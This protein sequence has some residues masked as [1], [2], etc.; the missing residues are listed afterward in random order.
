MWC[1][2]VFQ[3]LGCLVVETVFPVAG[4]DRI[5]DDGVRLNENTLRKLSEGKSFREWQGDGLIAGSS[6]EGLAVGRDWGHGEADRDHMWLC[7][8]D[9]AVYV[10][11]PGHQPPEHANLV[12]TPHKCPAAYTRL[13]VPHKD[14]LLRA[15]VRC[16]LSF[17]LSVSSPEVQQCVVNE[18]DRLWL[19][20]RHTLEVMQSPL[21][22]TISGPA[23]QQDGG[24]Y[25]RVY[26]LVCSGPHPAMASYKQRARKHWPSRVLLD[27]LVKQPMLLVMVGPK[28]AQD[29]CLMF[30][31]SWS[32]LELIL[33]SSLALWL[34]QGYVCFKYTVKSVLRSLRPQDSARDGRSLVGSYHLKTVFLRHLEENPP[35]QEGSPFQLML[36]LCQ[37]LQHY[38]LMGCLPHY[39][40]PECDLLRTVQDEER[41]YALQAVEQV[42]TDPLVA[43]FQSPSEPAVIYGDHKP[44]D[45]I[46]CFSYVSSLPSCPKRCEHLRW[47]LCHL[48]D[49]REGLYQKQLEEDGQIKVSGRPEL[50]T[51]SDYLQWEI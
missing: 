44:N 30:R 12:Y 18:D 7:G 37:D 8:G 23:G 22:E 11:P 3:M 48:D 31:I 42:I 9:L 47:L 28:D 14:R 5:R 25:E 50:V 39:L 38:L 51:L 4:L 26:S 10:L 40:L 16:S 24:L 45:L 2:V 43:I 13:Q 19:H 29:F 6:A 36:D 21:T 27:A 32:P 33:M 20:S 49:H 35:Q 17:F 1:V 41:K 15:I 46:R 34:K